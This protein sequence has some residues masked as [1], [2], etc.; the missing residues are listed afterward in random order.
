M[1]KGKTSLAEMLSKITHYKLQKVTR[2]Q[3]KN[4]HDVIDFLLSTAKGKYVCIL[5]DNNYS[6]SHVVEVDCSSSPKLIWDCAESNAL[7][8]SR[9][10]LDRCTGENTTCRVIKTIGEIVLKTDS[11]NRKL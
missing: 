4:Q 9:E 3:Q 11:K 2:K 8:L 6:Q 1:Y 5:Q 10:N 7:L